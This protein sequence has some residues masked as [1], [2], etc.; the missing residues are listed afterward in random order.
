[1]SGRVTI[2]TMSKIVTISDNNHHVW[3]GDNA[4]MSM[5]AFEL[6]TKL[7]TIICVHLSFFHDLLTHLKCVYCG[8][9]DIIENESETTEE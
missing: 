2:T 6:V 1:M 4:P 9:N 7:T 5:L 8:N 3:K